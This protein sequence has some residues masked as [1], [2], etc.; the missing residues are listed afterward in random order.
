MKIDPPRVRKLDSV[1][2]GVLVVGLAFAFAGGAPVAEAVWIMTV[3]RG[4]SFGD[5]RETFLMYGLL[6]VPY[7]A[8]GYLTGWTSERFLGP[9]QGVWSACLLAL[10]CGAIFFGIHPVSHW[11]RGIGYSALALASAAIAA[12]V[13]LGAKTEWRRAC[14]A[15]LRATWS[16]FRGDGA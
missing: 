9:R 4:L 12:A 13:A 11:Q 14:G 16:R 10:L 15:A 5:G 6:A 2:P 7:L 3:M 1:P 8:A